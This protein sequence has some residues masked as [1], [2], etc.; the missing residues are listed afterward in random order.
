MS[1]PYD[2]MLDL[3]HHVSSGHPQMSME[4]RAAQ[5]SP[6]AALTGY[7]AVIEETA[8]RTVPKLELTENSQEEIKRRL[9]FLAGHME[10][11]MEVSVTYFLPDR[12]KAGGA[13][14]TAVGIIKRINNVERVL[15]MEDG[16][17]ISIPDILEITWQ[18]K[19]SGDW[20]S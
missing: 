5:F 16:T 11:R 20:K 1:K 19:R 10:Q 14:I 2:D 4:E 17:R 7:E 18:R 15:W 13:Y 8:R 3:P 12:K 9:D 6:F